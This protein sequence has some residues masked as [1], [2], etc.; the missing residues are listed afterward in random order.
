MFEFRKPQMESLLNDNFQ[1]KRLY[2]KHQQLD[3]T[4][5]QV[6]DGKIPMEELELVRLKKQ[7]LNAKD[8]LATMMTELA[9]VG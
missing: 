1:F 6:E 5:E 8:Q 7:K 4:I 9:Q 3:H 2:E